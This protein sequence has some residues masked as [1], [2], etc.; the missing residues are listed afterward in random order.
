[1]TTEPDDTTTTDE[2][3]TTDGWA[4]TQPAAEA[5]EFDDADEF[6]DS[7]EFDDADEF[8]D[9]DPSWLPDDIERKLRYF[10]VAALALLALIALLRFYFATSATINELIAPAYQSLFQALFNL[11]ILLLS[12]AGILWQ[13]RELR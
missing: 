9:P 6:D 2:Q 11:T 7:D 1:M 10:V 5:T 8:D 3:E 13:A 4:N 12:G